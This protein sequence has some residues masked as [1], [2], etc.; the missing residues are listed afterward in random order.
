MKKNLLI[1]LGIIIAFAAVSQD[2]ENG[3]V[4][5]WEMNGSGTDLSG[6]GRNATVAG[7]T[8]PLSNSKGEANEAWYFD[9]NNNRY[10]YSTITINDGSI[11]FLIKPES[12]VA[13]SGNQS[14]ILWFHTYLS[15]IFTRPDGRIDIE[16]NSSGDHLIF[17]HKLELNIWQ[18]ITFVKIGNSTNL[19]VNGNYIETK[20]SLTTELKLKRIGNNSDYR[21]F[22]GGIDEVRIY[23]RA[24]SPEEIRLLFHKSS[25]P[26]SPWTVSGGTIYRTEGSVGIGTP[27]T[28]NH[29]LAVDGSIGAREITIESDTWSDFVF[30]ESYALRDLEEVETFIQQHHHLPEIPSEAEVINDGINLGEMDAKLLMKIEELTLYLIQQNKRI[31]ALEEK[32]EALLE[33][34]QNP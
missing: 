25:F 17:D 29:K 13:G 23:S 30:E 10:E 7:G 11:S 28:G 34:I 2:L 32:N 22:K 15:R 9:G 16:M 8:Q 33:L 24:L 31:K 26:E 12:F 18:Q 14:N 21:N 3:L 20:I 1:L 6:N 5:Y 27:T 19:Y 4:A